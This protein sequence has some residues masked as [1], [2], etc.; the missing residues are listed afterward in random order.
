MTPHKAFIL[1]A[2]MGTRMRPYTDTIPK[3]LVAVAGHSLIDRTLDHLVEAGITDITVNLHYLGK[4]LEDHLGKRNDVRIR[5]SYEDELLDTGG[6]I[7]K[8]IAHFGDEPFFVISGDSLWSDGPDGSA[9]QKLNEA[10]DSDKM[11]ILLLLQSTDSMK[12][13]KGIGDYHLEPDGRAV[14]SHTQE[15]TYMFTSI[16]INKPEIFDG[17]AQGAFSYLDLMDQAQKRGRLF[18]LVHDGNWHHISTPEDL[19]SVNAALKK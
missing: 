14:R 7:A 2:G 16:R 1:A 10:W 4:K 18:G 12:L 13:T 19:D 11:D 15:G 5:L 6:G 9:L 8:K 17:C 3:P